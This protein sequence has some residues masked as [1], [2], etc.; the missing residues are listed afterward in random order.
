MIILQNFRDIFWSFLMKI[1]ILLGFLGLKNV[2]IHNFDLTHSNKS[3]INIRMRSGFDNFLNFFIMHLYQ[4][5]SLFNIYFAALHHKNKYSNNIS[6]LYIL[7][8]SRM[9][10]S[11]D[12][13]AATKNIA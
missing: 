10:R 11:I 2:T 8:Q 4:Y 1:L 5:S 13:T 6:F 12:G 7:R 9:Y 3:D